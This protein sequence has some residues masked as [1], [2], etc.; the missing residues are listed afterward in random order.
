MNVRQ[1]VLVNVQLVIWFQSSISHTTL[2]TRNLLGPAH[3]IQQRI[4]HKERSTSHF[5]LE[6]VGWFSDMAA[7]RLPEYS[8]LVMSAVN[9]KVTGDVTGIFCHSVTCLGTNQCCWDRNHRP[10]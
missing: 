6:E 3:C 1:Y 4:T 5:T 7:S 10:G 9:G 2:A 8:S